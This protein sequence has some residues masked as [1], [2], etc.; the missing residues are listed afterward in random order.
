MVKF[1]IKGYLFYNCSVT[2]LK[3]KNASEYQLQY[4][5]IFF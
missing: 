3:T 2:F 5:D 1:K 4:I